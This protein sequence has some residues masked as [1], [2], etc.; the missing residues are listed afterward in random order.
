[1]VIK[2]ASLK[3]DLKREFEGDW[4]EFPTWDGVAFKVSSFNKPEYQ[5]ARDL[6]VRKMAQSLGGKQPTEAERRAVIGAV[7]AEHVL[8]DWRGFDIPF[9]KEAA[10]ELLSQPEGYHLFSAIEWCANQLTAVKIEFQDASAGKSEQP[11]DG[12]S[13]GSKA[14]AG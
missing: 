11:S 12:S 8:H 14:T 3:A 5:T 7:V 13:K 2:L 9:S 4:V 10:K 1:M 6:A